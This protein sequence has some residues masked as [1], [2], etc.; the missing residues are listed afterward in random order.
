MV[1][2]HERIMQALEQVARETRKAD[3]RTNTLEE[4]S[5]TEK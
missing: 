2:F 4:N 5:H 3:D 1:T